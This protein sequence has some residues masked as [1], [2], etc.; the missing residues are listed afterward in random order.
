[1]LFYATDFLLLLNAFF[2]FFYSVEYD[3]L[4]HSRT[5]RKRSITICQLIATRCVVDRGLL[6]GI[7][8]YQLFGRE[9]NVRF[10]CT[11]H[12]YFHTFIIM[13]SVFGEIADVTLIHIYGY[14]GIN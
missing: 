12:L 10:Y 8:W 3:L 9:K 14:Y 4:K 1:M 2:G 7:K 6:L 11:D 13:F 5:L